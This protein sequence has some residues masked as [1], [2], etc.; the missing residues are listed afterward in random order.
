MIGLGLAAAAVA[1]LILW[2]HPAAV[3]RPTGR[4]WCWAGDRR[5]R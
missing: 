4:T 3:V 1:A 2:V 5:C